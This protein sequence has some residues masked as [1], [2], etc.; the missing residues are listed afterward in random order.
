MNLE[1]METEQSKKQLVAIQ[2]K[3]SRAQAQSDKI[4][5]MRDMA[6]YE[7]NF[8]DATGLR[9]KLLRLH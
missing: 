7:V 3:Q 4:E 2:L 9:S 8:A 1:R 5:L 6:T